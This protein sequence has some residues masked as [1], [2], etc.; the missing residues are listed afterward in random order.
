[1]RTFGD[2]VERLLYVT[3]LAVF[4]AIAITVG[5]VSI[6]IRKLSDLGHS[7]QDQAAI[8]REHTDCL[9]ILSSTNSGPLSNETLQA[10]E[11]P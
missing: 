8:T 3:L 10:C 2:P 9:T 1:M 4:V 7:I 11:K 6:Q 5:A